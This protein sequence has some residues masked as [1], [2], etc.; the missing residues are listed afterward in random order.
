[1][2]PWFEIIDSGDTEYSIPLACGVWTALALARARRALLAWTLTFGA[3]AAVVLLSK[4]GFRGWGLGI[5]ALD[6]KS[7]SGHAARAAALWPVLLALLARAAGLARVGW[8]VV[9]GYGYAVLMAVLLVR[10]DRH[11]PAEAIAGLVLGACASAVFLRHALPPPAHAGGA[12]RAVLGGALAGVAVFL[13]EPAAHTGLITRT[14]LYLSGQ[15]VPYSWQTWRRD[16][17]ALRQAGGR[18]G[19]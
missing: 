8:P 2:S 11:A 12:G 17:A 14:A 19:G 4:I 6:F 7:V 18:P 15:P 13:A 9:L 3:A 5:A 16:D 10:F 1:M